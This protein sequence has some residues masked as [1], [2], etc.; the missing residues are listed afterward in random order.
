[1]K[2][3]V[4]DWEAKFWED[5]QSSS[6]EEPSKKKVK[7]D[8]LSTHSEKNLPVEL[9]T[10]SSQFQSI[11]NELSG[12]RKQVEQLEQQLKDLQEKN[13]QKDE[14]ILKLKNPGSSPH[15]DS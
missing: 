3:E 13:Q 5:L 6:E 4:L 11:L 14:E 9:E 12:K 2:R 7:S 15:V 1:L 10:I 8:Q